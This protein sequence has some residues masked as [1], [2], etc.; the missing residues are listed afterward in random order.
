MVLGNTVNIEDKGDRKSWGRYPLVLTPSQVQH[1]AESG[2]ERIH[3]KK[4]GVI[5]SDEL[6][7]F[8]RR[9]LKLRLEFRVPEMLQ[10][11]QLSA[12]K[13]PY[14]INFFNRG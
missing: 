9:R 5:G 11:T 13:R 6:A 2:F 3:N 14:S 1:V 8:R 7:Y 10:T 4:C 12:I